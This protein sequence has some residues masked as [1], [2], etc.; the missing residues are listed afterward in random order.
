VA[1]NGEAALALVSTEQPD[2]VFL[3]VNIPGK[4][5]LLEIIASYQAGPF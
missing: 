2:V 3:D 4:S 1:D 5:G